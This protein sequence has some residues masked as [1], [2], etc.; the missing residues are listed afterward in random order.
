VRGHQLGEIVGQLRLGKAVNALIEVLADAPD[1]AGIGLDGLRLQALELEVLE[2]P[3]VLPVEV[4]SR[5]CAHAG[6][7][8]RKVAKSPLSRRGSDRAD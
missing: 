5:C 1:G 6:V 2:M 8:S 4:S 7:S 3:L